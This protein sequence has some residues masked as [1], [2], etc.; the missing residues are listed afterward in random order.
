MN[1]NRNNNDAVEDE[2]DV[3]GL[4]DDV[5]YDDVLYDDVLYDDDE[6][7]NSGYLYNEDGSNEG[8]KD[9]DERDSDNGEMYA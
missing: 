9:V 3:K 1:I 7:G 2:S 8:S 4:Y 6:S 5:S